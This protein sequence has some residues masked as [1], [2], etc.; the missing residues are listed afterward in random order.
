MKTL[1]LPL[2]LVAL[3]WLPAWLPEALDGQTSL[4]HSE[5]IQ[6][7]FPAPKTVGVDNINGS[8][9]VIGYNGQQVQLTAVRTDEADTQ[10]L[11]N[12]SLAEVTLKTEE[13]D[14]EL[15]IYPDG[16]FRQPRSPFDHWDRR[17]DRYRTNFEFTLKVPYAMNLDLR[18]VNKGGITVEDVHGH[19][20]VREVNGAVEMKGMGG[21]GKVNSVNGALHVSFTQNPTGPC[22]FKTI[23][24]AVEVHLK[25][26]LAADLEYKT[27]H[28]GIFT[29]FDLNAAPTPVAGTAESKNGR[30]VYRSH[31]FS[32]GR[33]GSG[34][35]LLSFETLNGEIHI[36][37]Q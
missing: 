31:G 23:N 7:T 10:E 25:P 24:G 9:H 6:R 37:N 3:A 28:G 27:M 22:S 32:R 35:P 21:D 5:T 29:D 1:L 13:K 20:D 2:S 4:K 34:G 33:V 14:G 18:N 11:L 16:P 8:I 15:Q 26:G 36:L 30:F 12:R 17:E 19:F